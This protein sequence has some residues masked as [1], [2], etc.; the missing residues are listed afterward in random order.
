MAWSLLTVTPFQR[1]L[2]VEVTSS[3]FL[4]TAATQGVLADFNSVIAA[5][6]AARVT[7]ILDDEAMC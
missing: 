4:A 7:E 2:S 3:Y 5:S 1:L 6:I